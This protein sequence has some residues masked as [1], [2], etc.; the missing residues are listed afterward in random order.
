MTATSPK[1]RPTTA[2]K[3]RWIYLDYADGASKVT[4]TPKNEDRFVMSVRDAAEAC[5]MAH[6]RDAFVKQFEALLARLAQWLKE[7]ADNF[8]EAFVTIRDSG[9]LFVVLR[10]GAR[11]D[12][13]FED[14][15]T[16]L[17]LEI[18]QDSKF[19]HIDLNVLS[20]PKTSETAYSSFLHPEHTWVFRHGK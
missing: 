20:L 8:C 7:H 17:D 2:G 19:D 3:P 16:D 13:N 18:A 6:D 15:L 10:D 11:F 14:T 5:Q 12:A 1:A 9:L 4:V